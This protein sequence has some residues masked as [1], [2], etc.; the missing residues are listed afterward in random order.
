VLVLSAG[1]VRAVPPWVKLGVHAIGM[2]HEDTLIPGASVV[3][4]KTATNAHIVEFLHDMGIS[5]ELFDTADAVP[6]L[7]G[8]YLERDELVRFGIDTRSFGETSWRFVDKPM[9]VQKEFFVRTGEQPPAYP[10][11]VLRVSCGAGKLRGLSLARQRPANVPV[12]ATM[13]PLRIAINGQRVSLANATKFGIDSRAT[14]I[15]AATLDAANDKSA[16]TIDGFDP[17]RVGPDSLITLSMAGFS[18]AYAKLRDA[19]TVT[20]AVNSGCSLGEEISH[21]CI[22]EAL[23]NRK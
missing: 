3:A 22:M 8:K 2:D 6:H 21:A 11:V 18:A 9:M 23:T 13:R 14:F 17:G 20:S 16:I 10:N 5:K 7:S 12:D 15:P 1:A 4:S 19:C